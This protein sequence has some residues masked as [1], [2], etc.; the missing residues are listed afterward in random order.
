MLRITSGISVPLHEISFTAVRS[1]GPGGQ[2]VNKVNS[3]VQ[4]RFDI[5]KS[6]L[7]EY[8]KSRLRAYA[9]QRITS[10]GVI[11]IKAQTHR[12]QHL[13]RQDALERLAALM[14]QALH[15]PKVRRATRPTRASRER[16]LS[17]KNRLGQ[18]KSLRGRVRDRDG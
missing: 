13:N 11:V 2:N 15:R 18:K 1:Q 14:G 10:D 8:A 4:L 9:D 7:P 5:E 17:Q 16:R 12:L 6:S 3:A